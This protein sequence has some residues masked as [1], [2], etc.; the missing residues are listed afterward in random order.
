LKVT[1]EAPIAGDGT[2]KR[3]RNILRVIVCL[4]KH[5]R[6]IRYVA[7]GSG[8]HIVVIFGPALAIAFLW[9]WATLNPQP[10]DACDLLTA[11]AVGDTTVVRRAL[12]GGVSVDA[13]EGAALWLAASAGDEATTRLLLQ[14]GAKLSRNGNG[15]YSPLMMAAMGGNAR[16]IKL[17]LDAGADPNEVSDHGVTPLGI[18]ATRGDEAT[19]DLLLARGACVAG[20]AGLD[21]DGHRQWQPPLVNAV[22][23][24]NATP[25]LIRRLIS[26]GAD[27][28]A[29]DDEGMTAMDAAAAI[30]RAD[31]VEL[32]AGAGARRPQPPTTGVPLTPAR[33]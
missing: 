21:A 7:S 31:L 10:P 17:L 30:G 12:D 23:G 2:L 1:H 24:G 26:A 18:A 4:Q 5:L 11:A 6:C 22:R 33:E 29:C 19:V 27:V 13:S 32:L 20:I 28:N 8:R 25:N 3:H 16:V 9:G 14:R 15:D